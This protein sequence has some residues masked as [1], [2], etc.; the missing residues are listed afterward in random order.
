MRPRNPGAVKGQHHAAIFV[1]VAGPHDRGRGGGNGRMKVRV[2]AQQRI[3]ISENEGKNK[4]RQVRKRKRY[5]DGGFLTDRHPLEKIS[6]NKDPNGKVGGKKRRD[7]RN[8]GEEKDGGVL[9]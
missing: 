7:L 6:W 8:R 2:T 3:P 9:E 4:K 1:L 5:G